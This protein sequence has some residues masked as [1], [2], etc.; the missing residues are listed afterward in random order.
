M[1]SF[2]QEI[3]QLLAS[4]SGSLVYHLVILFSI[5]GAYLSVNSQNHAN[6]NDE[7]QRLLRGLA[8]L[9][10]LR[11]LVFLISLLTIQGIGNSHLSLPPFDRTLNAI[12]II[13]IIWLWVFP[14]SSRRIDTITLLVVLLTILMGVFTFISWIELA[15]D[16]PFNLT[17]LDLSWTVFSLLLALLGEMLLFIRKPIGWE[18]GFSMFLILFLGSILHIFIRVESDFPGAIRLSQIAAFPILFTLSQ[19][20]VSATYKNNIGAET[21]QRPPDEDTD[22]DLST[23]KPTLKDQV[24]ADMKLISSYFALASESDPKKVCSLLTEAIAKT[25]VADLCLLLSAPDQN[26]QFVLLCG[27]D[28]IREETMRGTSISSEI[29]PR[30]A[31]ASKRKKI[32]RLRSSSKSPDLKGF[33]EILNLPNVGG[34]LATPVITIDSTLLAIIVLLSPYSNRSWSKQ[35]ESYLRDF[36]PNIALVL[37]RNTSILPIDDNTII[38]PDSEDLERQTEELL[39]ELEEMRQNV[40]EQHATIGGLEALLSAAD[41]TEESIS[42]LKEEN[43]RLRELIRSLENVE[44]SGKTDRDE[45]QEI[46]SKLQEAEAQIIDLQKAILEARKRIENTASEKE[47]VISSEQAEVIASIAQDVR[48]PLSSISGYTDLLL[49]ESVGILGAN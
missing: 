2:F 17:G 15:A 41:R 25:L 5:M 13:I 14:Q 10:V 39:T 29:L 8:L 43:R 38:Q 18:Y 19:R 49:G 31:A 34:L 4:T 20:I 1:V 21:D 42:T 36:S 26:G 3:V 44:P 23:S 40:K 30:V 45:N 35:D 48:Q 24:P 12:S 37:N 32:L 6:K 22:K 11:L 27:Y 7:A 28:L 9:L 33:A 16:G 46:R 47:Q